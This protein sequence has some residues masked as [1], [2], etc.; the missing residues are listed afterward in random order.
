MSLFSITRPVLNQMTE[1]HGLKWFMSFNMVHL[2]SINQV[3]NI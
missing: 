2:P 3:H 1:L